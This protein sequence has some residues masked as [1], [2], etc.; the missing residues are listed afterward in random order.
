[1]FSALYQRDDI[2]RIAGAM[3]VILML[4]CVISF[5]VIRAYHFGT[6]LATLP[7]RVGPSSD[8]EARISPRAVVLP[9]RR[10]FFGKP[11]T[12]VNCYTYK[13]EKMNNTAVVETVRAIYELSNA[14]MFCWHSVREPWNVRRAE[15]QQTDVLCNSTGDCR[16][17]V[18][19]MIQ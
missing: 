3:T 8:F 4:S 9:T 10:P 19:E 5:V 14:Y 15:V 17:I 6:E 7:Q 12:V 13:D 11:E 18:K 2:K 16:R 1:M